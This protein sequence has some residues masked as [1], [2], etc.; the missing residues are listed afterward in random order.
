VSWNRLRLA[1]LISE[2]EELSPR[3]LG[4]SFQV[5]DERLVQRI[6][7]SAER[8]QGCLACREQDAEHG[9]VLLR[10]GG[11]GYLLPRQT[12]RETRVPLLPSRYD[13][14]VDE[15][16]G[17]LGQNEA[18]FRKVNERS[19]QLNESFAT[20]TDTFEVICECA[21]SGCVTQISI[22]SDAYER[23]RTDATLF[24]VAPRHENSELE[25]IVDT[26]GGYHIVRKHAGLPARIAEETDP[27]R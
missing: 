24:I 9:D 19:E 26:Q 17:R 25:D 8:V 16:A 4:D 7:G 14:F 11:D 10:V 6:V 5:R 3:P 12:T 1:V 22:A 21:D 27:R 2:G 15:R 18:L 20:V 13:P 23:V